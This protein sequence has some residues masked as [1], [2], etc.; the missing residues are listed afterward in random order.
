M[1]TAKE[2]AERVEKMT[3]ATVKAQMQKIE[4]LIEV[5]TGKAEKSCYVPFRLVPTTK[6]RLED[7]E[8]GYKVSIV[9][10]FRDGEYTTISW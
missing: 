8:L 1:M 9:E 2:A 6:K 5:A 4:N 7:P 3:D 10:D